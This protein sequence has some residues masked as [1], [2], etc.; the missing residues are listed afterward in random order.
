MGRK[1]KDV[2]VEAV[3]RLAAEGLAEYQI[4]VKLGVCPDTFRKRKRDDEAIRAAVERGREAARGAVANAIYD[5][6]LQ[7]RENPRFSTI[8]IWY[9][10]TQMGWK[11]QAHLEVTGPGGGPVGVRFYLP[12]NGRKEESD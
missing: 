8:A 3:E 4:A 10:K 6:A 12:E 11:D 7:V 2:D 1:K 9:S 5:A